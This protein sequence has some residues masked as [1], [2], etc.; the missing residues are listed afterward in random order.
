M[1]KRV[2]SDEHRANIS[3]ACKGR[4]TWS[5]GKKMSK[6]SLYKNMKSH[7]RFDVSIEYLSQFLD[8]EKLKTLNKCITNRSGRFSENTDWYISY[9]DKFYSDS[10]FNKI[11]ASWVRNGK[12]AYLRPSVDHIVSRAKGGTNDID[13]LQFLSWFENRC[14]NDMT[15]EQWD[16]TKNNIWEYFI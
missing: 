16:D 14:K 13:N 8:I 12:D 2:F 7:L 4:K 10:Q 6:E 9:I 1:A 3:K 11:Y 5:K 15:Q